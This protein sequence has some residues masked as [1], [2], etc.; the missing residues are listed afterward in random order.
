MLSPRRFVLFGLLL[1]SLLC[2]SVLAQQTPKA[3]AYTNTA[4]PTTNFGTSGT[5]NV[6]SP[7]QTSYI[8]FDLSS[9]PAGYTSSNIAKASLKLYVNAV[10]TAGS[11]NVDYVNGTW[12]ERTITSALSP[13]LGTTI[14]ASVPLTKSM[15]GDYIII[16]ITSAVDAWL[17]GTQP[18][19]GIALVANSPL[20]RRP[21]RPAGAARHSGS[22]RSRRPDWSTRSNRT[23]WNQQPRVVGFAHPISDQRLG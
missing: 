9:I 6:D 21:T 18:N 2:V 17:N 5:L 23:G 8:Q 10:A 16:D 13:A 19:D 1:P 22:F 7:S 15:Q 12:S 14:A 11:F 20:T 4:S 3:D